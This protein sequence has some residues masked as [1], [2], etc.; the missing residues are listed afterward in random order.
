MYNIKVMVCTISSEYRILGGLENFS[1]N[2]STLNEVKK[3]SICRSRAV[4]TEAS[5]IIDSV[6]FNI[7]VCCD[8][9]IANASL[10]SN[11]N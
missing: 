5:I 8:V 1:T 10:N 9:D 7:L 4:G 3:D 2:I 11:W 6:P